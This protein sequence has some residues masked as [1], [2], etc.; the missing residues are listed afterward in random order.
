MEWLSPLFNTEFMMW[1]RGPVD[2]VET[3]WGHGD[4]WTLPTTIAPVHR[5]RLNG[6]G[7]LLWKE[8]SSLV[9][10]DLF[11]YLYEPTHYG[12]QLRALRVLDRS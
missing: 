5:A 11:S 8:W 10:F 6:S 4:Q 2:I 9:C 12:Q 1:A 3:E 7:A